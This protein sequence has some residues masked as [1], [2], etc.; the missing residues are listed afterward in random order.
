MY[1]SH[2]RGVSGVDR[3]TPRTGP[4]IPAKISF[5]LFAVALVLQYI[6]GLA[7][8]WSI[9]TSVDVSSVTANWARVSLKTTVA[10]LITL[11]VSK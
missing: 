4:N 11:V 7:Y 8:Y 3:V 9:V 2:E 6:A 1:L 5:R 10:A